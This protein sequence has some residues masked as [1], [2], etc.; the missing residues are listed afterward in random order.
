MKHL[1]DMLR[2][3]LEAREKAYAPYSRFRVGACLRT[4]SGRLYAGCNVENASYPEGQCA[5][6]SALGALVLGGDREIVEVLVVAEGAEPCSPCGGC[7]Q[8][9]MELATPQTPV[10]MVSTT[11]KR[12]T[13]TLGELLPLAFDGH[14]LSL[15]L[16]GNETDTP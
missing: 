16:P 5:E 14:L 2:L 1:D 3:A 10:H 12:K 9:L 11:G 7:R 4:A 15:R 13:M 8:R 6:T